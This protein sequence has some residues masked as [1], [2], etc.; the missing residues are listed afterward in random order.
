MRQASLRHAQLDGAQHRCLI[1]A[2]A[3]TLPIKNCFAS[4]ADCQ[5]GAWKSSG[6]NNNPLVV[7]T[8]ADKSMYANKRTVNGSDYGFGNVVIS[9]DPA[10]DLIRFSSGM[11]DCSIN[12]TIP[13][14]VPA[15]DGNGY[16]IT[17]V[18]IVISGGVQRMAPWQ[19]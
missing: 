13:G 12:W 8:A 2:L 10:G 17:P 1:I 11:S 7:P 18:G 6:S 15:A 19:H 16:L 9:I 4:S 5:S 3:Q 14:C